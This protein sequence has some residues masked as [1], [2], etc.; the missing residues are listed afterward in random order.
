MLWCPSFA[1]ESRPRIFRN[2]LLPAP[3]PVKTIRK[4]VFLCELFIQNNFTSPPPSKSPR[5]SH[6]SKIQCVRATL[7]GAKFLI[8]QRET[9]G[10]NFE[11]EN[12]FAN[13]TICRSAALQSNFG[14]FFLKSLITFFTHCPYW[15]PYKSAFTSHLTAKI[16]YLCIWF[17]LQYCL[18]TS[19]LLNF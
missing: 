12:L 17:Y 10:W 18:I 6:S 9:V 19:H 14:L 2:A 5:T 4:L 1:D 11:D 16:V 7:V 8:L 13:K 15:L 3:F